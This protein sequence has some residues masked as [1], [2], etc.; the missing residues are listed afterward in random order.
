MKALIFLG[1]PGA[2]K[3]TQA[4]EVS[5]AFSI[6]QVSTG[7]ILREAAR[8]Q[9]PMGLAAKADMEAGALVPDEVVCGIVEERIGEP[10]CRKGFILDGF[11]RTLAQAKFVDGM[12][13]KKS[14]GS[15]LA[16]N[17]RVDEDILLK[18]LTGRRTCSVCGEIYNIY[19]NPP[20]KQGVCDRD[21][22]KLLQRAD[23][24][25]ATIRQRLAA[26]ENQT[27]PLIAYYRAKNLL[28]EVDGNQDPETIARGLVRFL[29]TV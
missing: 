25:E 17:I 10:D 23:D 12:L 24:N 13:E 4:R 3:G 19:F 28:H 27:A 8:K 21:G 7:D 14:F 2:G 5:K 15:P 6:P 20:K 9:A 22:G 11:P 18:R 1:A 29:R 16:V 26:Y